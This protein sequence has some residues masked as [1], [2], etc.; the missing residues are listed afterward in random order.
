[1]PEIGQTVTH[2]PNPRSGLEDLVLT[3]LTATLRAKANFPDLALIT[4]CQPL[5]RDR[6]LVQV[7][8]I[9]DGVASQSRFEDVATS[10]PRGSLSSIGMRGMRI[11]GSS[12]HVLRQVEVAEREGGSLTIPRSAASASESAA[13]D[14]QASPF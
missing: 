7:P 3:A 8:D 1:M 12:T 11:S 6:L 4:N 5:L 9:I 10:V 13:T 14:G 2:F